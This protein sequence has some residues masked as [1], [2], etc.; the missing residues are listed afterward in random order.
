MNWFRPRNNQEITTKPVRVPDRTTLE[1]AAF[2]FPPDIP[3]V[4]QLIRA[5]FFGNERGDITTLE[6]T[7]INRESN[8]SS[9]TINVLSLVNG[10]RIGEQMFMRFTWDR[11]CKQ[12]FYYDKYYG[13][14][15][16]AF[17]QLL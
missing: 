13:K 7:V 12:W 16:L 8:T 14:Y 9:V 6:T 2:D 10:N 4:G 15:R 1:E 11:S 3:R 5:A 17:I